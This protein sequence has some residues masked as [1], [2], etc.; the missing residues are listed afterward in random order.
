M[1]RSV[2]RTEPATLSELFALTAARRSGELALR[3]ADTSTRLTWSAYA[4]GV[5]EAAG[6]LAGVGVRRGDTVACW[7][8]NRPEFHV[9]DAAALQ[10]GAVPFS[11]YQTLSVG[12]AEYVIGDAGS[13]VLITEPAYLDSALAV[14]DGGNT[15]V[16]WIVLVVGSHACALTWDELLACASEG[17]DCDASAAA[18]EPDDLATLIYT[19][20]RTGPPKGVQLSHRNIVSQMATIADRLAL[21]DGLRTVSWLPMAHA[22]ERLC[23]HYLPI[24]RGWEV[25]TCTEPSAIARL[26]RDARPEFFFS[27][28]RLWEKLRSGVLA[29][30]DDPALT[31]LGDAVARV[32]AGEG[33][34]D[35]ELAASIRRRLGLSDLKTAI[36]GAAPCSAE[37]IEFWHAVGVPLVEVYGMSES[38]GVA[39]VNPPARIRIG[40]VGTAL[41]GVEVRLGEQGEILI[42]GPLVM[43]GYRNSPEKTAEAIDP[44]G[45]LHTGDVG[46]L[47]EDGYLR[48]V[49]QHAADIER[50]FG[51]GGQ[52]C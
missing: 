31:E 50:R 13:R 19:S 34:Q 15:A 51:I 41:D 11:V 10:L 48:I 39:T 2:I 40:T 45:W 47:D 16:E 25:T 17:F 1:T 30:A 32:R 35:G 42:R 38:T 23:T 46:L 33:P 8:S 14:R 18:V 12:Q 21:S 27:P 24:A 7:L 4:A 22:A 5:R 9:A 29:G 43:R 49:D 37:V 44:D 26:V 28:P 20:G 52:G 3:S 6:G 36:V